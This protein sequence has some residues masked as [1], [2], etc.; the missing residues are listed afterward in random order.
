[1]SAQTLWPVGCDG[2]C[3]TVLFVASEAEPL[4]EETYF[5]S[6]ACREWYEMEETQ[7]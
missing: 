7:V 4:E 2:Q 3:G 6:D 1:M 5:C